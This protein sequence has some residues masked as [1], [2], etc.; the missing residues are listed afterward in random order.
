MWCEKRRV[1]AWTK[2]GSPCGA[3]SRISAFHQIAFQVEHFY[4]QQQ[5]V[6]L[7]DLVKELG[8]RERQISNF[9]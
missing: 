4:C 2:R 7:T 1:A 6:I 9:G 5:R 3:L 8:G